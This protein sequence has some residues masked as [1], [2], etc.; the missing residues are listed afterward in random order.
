MVR[1]AMVKIGAVG[2]ALIVGVGT[3]AAAAK[4]DW[5][6]YRGQSRDGVAVATKP[7]D[8]AWR[9]G[10]PRVAWRKPLGSA[11]SQL[12]VS[13]DAVFTGAS[14]EEHDY[15]V[16]L[17]AA[18]GE[19]VWRVPLG[20][21]FV[22]EFGNGPRSTP[23]VDEDVVFQLG[24]RGRLVAVKTTDGAPVFQ[25]DLTERFGAA[26]PRFGFSG[27]PLI[28]GDLVV[29]EVG[30][31]EKGWLAA[32]DKKTGETRWTSGKGPA[33]YSSPIV[34]ELGGEQQL[35]I[36]RGKTVLGLDLAGQTL[37][38]HEL[39]EGAVAM[40][41]WVGDGRIFVSSSGDTGC[42]LLA[43]KRTEDGITVEQLWQN[44]NMRNHFNSSVLA[45]DHIYGFDNATL[46]CLSAA[47]GELVWAKRGLGKGS[48]L[49]AGDRLLVVSDHGK[50][51]LADAA[52][53]EFHE[54]GSVDALSGKS[55][56]AP[57]FSR[58]RLYVRNLT[59]ATCLDFGG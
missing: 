36:I 10:G 28:V 16:R 30:G 57:S 58:G 40:P 41:L 29:L 52:P 39:E 24:A 42:V 33:G 43:L 32:L 6:Q 31:P 12:V 27:S 44:R 5:P 53:H 49:V 59:E 17:D 55:W 46:K 25:V 34:I 11:F 45:G 37:W 51:V 20:E 15:L 18:S 1:C 47:T 35:V 23:T 13:G 48:L 4:E 3:V 38:S 9:D 8:V 21:V 14:D 26:V 22:H 56:T 50:V 2:F 7:G 54:H 19:E